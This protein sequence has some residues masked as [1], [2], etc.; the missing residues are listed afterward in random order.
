MLLLLTG[1]SG[2]GK[3]TLCMRVVSTLKTAGLNVAGVLTLPYFAKGEKIRLDLEDARTGE[4]RTL[5]ERTVKGQGTADLAW[6]FDDTA[7]Q[8]G[9]Q[10]LQEATP[11]DVLVVDELGPLELIHG[12]GWIVALDVLRAQNY[13]NALVVVR[14][15]LV[16]TFRAY[17]KS[18]MQVMSITPANREELYDQIVNRLDPRIQENSH[19]SIT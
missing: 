6:R 4:Q 3:T 2:C 16:E 12:S 5:A 7:L 9:A 8:K 19:K 13:R 11:C 17:L 18:D 15:E 1:E 10:I 14:P